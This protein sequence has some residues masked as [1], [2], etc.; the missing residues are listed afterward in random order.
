MAEEARLES[1]WPPKA[2]PGFESL[3]F[4][5]MQNCSNPAIA[6]FVFLWFLRNFESTNT[7][8]MK[9]LI[10]FVLCISLFASCSREA[11]D[12]TPEK[13]ETPEPKDYNITGRVLDSS[14]G[15]G[16]EAVVLSDGHQCVSTDKDGCFYMTGTPDS[17]KFVF[18]S[19][20]SGYLPPVNDGIPLFYKHFPD[21]DTEESVYD[22]GDFSLSPVANPDRFTILV[23]A[24][25]QPRQRGARYDRI[26]Y[27]SLE[28]CT[29]LYRELKDVAATIT[30]R[31]VYG[32]C[33]G[34]LVH[35][36]MSLFDHYAN[37]M[38]TLGFPTYNIIGNHDNDTEAEDDDSAAIPYEQHFGPRN[39]S[40][41]IGGIHFVMLDNLIM[42]KGSD[43]V[44][45]S[46]DQGLTDEIWEWLQADLSFIPESSILMTFAHSPMFKVE[47]GNER[48]NTAKHGPDY[49][50]LINNYSE[51]H[52]WAGHTHTG[53]NYVYP[54]SHRHKR[55]NV[56]TLARS[57]GEL[58]T[59]EYL[60]SGTPRGFTIVE[61]DHGKVSWR[62]HPTRYQR[63][64]W[65]GMSSGSWIGKPSYKWSD[66]TF[67]GDG[68]AV[69]KGGGVLDEEYQMHVYP[70]GAYGDDY[71]YA[72][73]FLWDDK[74]QIP[75]FTQ[76]GSSPVTME[77]V[78]T[79]DRHDLAT[80][81]FRTMYKTYSST[82]N[83]NDSYTASVTGAITTLFRAK[84]EAS[85]AKGSVSVT[86]RF[87]NTYTRDT[88]W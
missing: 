79:D 70:R 55:V 42:K 88:Y 29:D 1:A 30:D 63:P 9:A 16:L 2:A 83:E 8:H 26:G 46:Y 50:D 25:P 47:N 48:T 23:S 38:S 59:N 54:S 31:Q 78:T 6:G 52:A 4:R 64:S 39:Y 69:M 76:E 20:P 65:Q 40:F 37:G 82:L 84:A 28:I 57:T 45:N 27:H 35:E 77:K 36:D 43:G 58:W 18:V 7:N 61:V 74:W 21:F 3:S 53:F 49:G 19:T 14:T 81:E 62:F 73:V 10:P 86:D 68:S 5:V 11:A 87:G 66:W 56:H 80:T 41:N 32:I 12:P 67:A 60:A 72:N 71:V 85:P 75:V 17:S 33:L 34:D 24:D 13:P 51:V 44:L 15:K 22:F